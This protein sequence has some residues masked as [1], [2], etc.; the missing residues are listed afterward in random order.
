MGNGE[1]EEITQRQQK[2][3]MNF[4]WAKKIVN[5]E[6]MSVFGRLNSLPSVNPQRKKT[7]SNF[8]AQRIKHSK[9]SVSLFKARY[10][11]GRQKWFP[12]LQFC[13]I[14][15]LLVHIYLHCCS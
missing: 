6:S 15:N 1:N 11:Y 8:N 9:T 5:E 10:R 12:E 7:S 14:L 3:N 4:K 2:Y 13:S